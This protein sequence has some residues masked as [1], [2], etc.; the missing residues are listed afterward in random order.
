V[1]FSDVNLDSTAQ[2]SGR[3]V[4][5]VSFSLSANVIY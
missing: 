5:F 3:T 2:V 1:F 4:K